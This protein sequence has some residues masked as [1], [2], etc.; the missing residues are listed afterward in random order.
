MLCCHGAHRSRPGAICILLLEHARARLRFLDAFHNLAVCGPFEA[1]RAMRRYRNMLFYALFI[2]Q[3]LRFVSGQKVNI[4]PRRMTRQSIVKN[5][6]DDMNHWT[7][8]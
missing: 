5:V 3:I 8:A 7:S 2:V 6:D 1:A 4:I